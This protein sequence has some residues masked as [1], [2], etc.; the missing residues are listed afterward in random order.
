MLARRVIATP[1]SSP[2]FMPTLMDAAQIGM[3]NFAPLDGISLRNSLEK[4][5]DAERA[6]FWHYPHYGNQGGAPAAAIRRG[7][8]KLI[9]WY[10][11][12][13]MELYDLLHDLGETE[14]LAARESARVTQMAMELEKWQKN[15]GARFP[16]KNPQFD[17]QKTN[18][19]A[20]K[21]K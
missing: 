11:D 1:V 5:P 2:D 17:P 19:R 12:D 7:N 9:H 4:K 8:W 20:A 15:M 3:N 21:R 13:S 6:L 10:E 16:Q 14:N 18:G